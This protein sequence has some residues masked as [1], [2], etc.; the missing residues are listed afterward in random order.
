MNREQFYS[1]Q[2]ENEI[3][4]IALNDSKALDIIVDLEENDFY[5]SNNKNLYAVIKGLWLKNIEIT[6]S[7]IVAEVGNS[8]LNTLGGISR[9]S[10]IQSGYVSSQ[11]L[12]KLIQ[13]IKGYRKR[14]DILELRTNIDKML[15][16]EKKNDVILSSITEKL[17][18]INNLANEDTGNIEVAIDNYIN[19]LEEKYQN[20]GKI[21]GIETKLKGL[22][23][24]ING[25][26][27]QEMTIIAGR[28]G[29]GKTTLA[30]NILL[31]AIS[32]NKNAALF[33]LEMSKDQ[34]FQ[35]LFSNIGLIDNEALKFGNL[36]DEQWLK[37]VEAQNKLM[38]FKNNFKVYD[39]ILTLNGII[40]NAKRLSKK[41]KLDL[42][43]VDYLQLI[44]VD[45]KPG[46]REQ[47]ISTIS[48]KLKLLSKELN[49]PVI[50]LSQ[51]S[52][53][54]EQRAD[55]RPMLSDLRESGSIEQDADIVIFCYRDEYYYAETEDK[56]ILEIIIGKNRNGATGTEKVAWIPQ[57]QRVTDLF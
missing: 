46:N 36:T 37:V 32:Q 13:A 16:E 33:N 38:R 54:C 4:A 51:L 47:E 6:I 34:I 2:L 35:K 40:S 24:R 50:V 30:N 55:H 26:N 10:E 14:R 9:L 17:D 11:G 39:N 12:K 21:T 56:N 29:S 31:K 18:N 57:Y 3:L 1:L 20:K 44:Q 27:K 23:K 41:G 25:L 48:R 19:V 15:N 5:N 28:P 42:V 22:D 7:T 8:G 52:R 49:I 43:I 45:G 53:A